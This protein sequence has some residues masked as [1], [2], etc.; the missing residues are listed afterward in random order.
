MCIAIFAVSFFTTHNSAFAAGQTGSSG[1]TPVSERLSNQQLSI[2]NRVADL[3]NLLLRSSEL[4]A[5]ENPTRASLLRRAVQL[6]KQVQLASSL[7]AAAEKLG[8]EQYSD[9]ISQQQLA[10]KNLAQIL[11]L[12][13][14]ENRGQRVREEREQVRRWIEETDRLLRMQ[15]ALRGR[16]EGGQDLEAARR[17][18]EQLKAKASEIADDLLGEETDP[19]QPAEESAGDAERSEDQNSSKDPSDSDSAQGDKPA[20]Q[21]AEE[22]GSADDENRQPGTEQSE[23]QQPE[24][25]PS[26]QKQSQSPS[27]DAD[28]QGSQ[29]GSKQDGSEQ[30][31]GQQDSSESNTPKPEQDEPPKTPTQKAGERLR[32]AQRKMQEAQKELEEA[33][34]DGAIDK[35]REA[36]EELRDAVA[37][38]EQIL[39]QLREEEI[40]RSLE[41][42][43]AR[44]RNMLSMQTKIVEETRR[45]NEISNGEPNRQVAIRA[46]KLSLEEQKVL[47]AGERAFSLLREEGSSA[48][49]PEAIEQ[50][51]AD[52]GNVIQRLSSGD[53]TALTLLIQDDI[54]TAL[55]EMIASL[56]AVQKE[57][58]EKKQQQQQGGGGGGGGGQQG[59]RPLVNKLAELRLV[60]TLQLRINRRTQSMSKLLDASDT[61]GQITEAEVL[62]E[63][64]QLAERELKIQ[65]VTLKIAGDRP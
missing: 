24:G 45:L 20:D 6:S 53:V 48:A 21:S 52:I 13:Q 10:K 26:D 19:N 49:F 63:V 41:S 56:V 54:V 33:Q 64:R 58:R 51:N 36:E 5:A 32:N 3:E 7:A 2:A 46:S 61:K 30:Q 4:E 17:N 55:E 25:K 62:K 42:L 38:L 35:Q 39:Q 47:R 60:K 43:E 37:E 27:G 65:K 44:L 23:T 15:G 8:G 22:S 11:T 28:Q 16:T 14:S 31:S 9:A 12:L 59:Q 34:R 50:V 1:E 40:E 57:N 18:Q 29:E